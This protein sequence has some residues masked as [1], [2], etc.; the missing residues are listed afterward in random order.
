MQVGRGM[1]DQGERGALVGVGGATRHL[2]CAV[3][4]REGWSPR[5]TSCAAQATPA[6][7][8]WASWP[9]PQKGIHAKNTFTL[10]ATPAG[11]A[12][13]GASGPAAGAQRGQVHAHAA[14]AGDGFAGR[15][16][17]RPPRVRPHGCLPCVLSAAAAR[18]VDGALVLLSCMAR[19][20]RQVPRW[21]VWRASSCCSAHAAAEQVPRQQ[22]ALSIFMME[23]VQAALGGSCK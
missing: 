13:D 3:M 7:T 23:L 18:P 19:S 11:R 8:R 5:G 2:V 9:A 15:Q 20:R 22:E 4:L 12:A 6:G 1:D 10:A 16:A 17:A 21:R 14:N